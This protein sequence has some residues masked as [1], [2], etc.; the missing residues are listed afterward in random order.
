MP[1]NKIRKIL[2]KFMQNQYPFMCWYCLHC[3]RPSLRNLIWNSSAVYSS[4]VTTVSLSPFSCLGF[5][6]CPSFSLH[7]HLLLTAVQPMPLF[8]YW[9]CWHA[10]MF[11]VV[12]SHTLRVDVKYSILSLNQLYFNCLYLYT[13]AH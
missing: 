5:I 4:W 11:Q 8:I 7:Y 2:V 10:N 12:P 1:T 3:C 6:L 13:G 9:G